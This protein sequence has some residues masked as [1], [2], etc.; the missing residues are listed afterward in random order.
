[1]EEH[2]NAA[3]GWVGVL[4]RV[5]AH[6]P[7]SSYTS[8]AAAFA[9]VITDS[10][11]A[12]PT[13][14]GE[15][16]LARHA[17]VYAYEFDDPSSPNVNGAKRPAFP[18]ARHTRPISL[19]LRPARQ[20]PARRRSLS[21]PGANDGVLLD[22]LRPYRQPDRPVR[23]GVASL[24]PAPRTGPS[25]LPRRPAR[26][27]LRRRAQLRVLAPRRRRLSNYRRDRTTTSGNSVKARASA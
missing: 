12:C 2:L 4:D 10:A 20:G 11:W 8:P 17:S 13:L 16:Q 15:A 3:T 26:D 25:A 19:S 22:Q 24:P 27:R 5:E 9:G 7:L 14:T 23:A 6:D 1:M 18:K 21:P